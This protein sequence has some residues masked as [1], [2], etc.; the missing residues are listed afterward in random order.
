MALKTKE[1]AKRGD[2]VRT[3]ER[4]DELPPLNRLFSPNRFELREGSRGYSAPIGR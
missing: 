1:R 3:I 4:R 2:E